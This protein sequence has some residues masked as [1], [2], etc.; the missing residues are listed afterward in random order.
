MRVGACIIYSSTT[1]KLGIRRFGSWL[2]FIF[3]VI[4][5]QFTN[6]L[7]EGSENFEEANSCSAS[8]EFSYFTEAQIHHRVHNSPSPVPIL[9]L[10]NPTHN[11][12]PRSLTPISTLSSHL[13]LGLPSGS[14]LQNFRPKFCNNFFLLVQ[15]HAPPISSSFL[16][17]FL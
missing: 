3:K 15:V 7:H 4:A 13:L 2:N 12:K 11:T 1:I 14:Y 17:S 9:N 5:C 10:I 8:Q 16:L 6:F